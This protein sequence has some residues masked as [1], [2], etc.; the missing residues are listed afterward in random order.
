MLIGGVVEDQV[1]DDADVAGVRLV[2]EGGEVCQ[3]AVLGRDVRVVGN[4][5]PAVKQRRR[6]MRRQPDRIDAEISQVV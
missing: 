2:E 3:R 6:V 1:Q 5:I 4:V